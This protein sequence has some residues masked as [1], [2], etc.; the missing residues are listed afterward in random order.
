MEN[1]NLFRYHS[2]QGSGDYILCMRLNISKYYYQ[3]MI[4]TCCPSTAGSGLGGMRELKLEEAPVFQSSHEPTIAS[5]R[6]C[7]SHLPLRTVCL[8]HVD[9]QQKAVTTTT[10]DNAKSSDEPPLLCWDPGSKA[11]WK[12]QVTKSKNHTKIRSTRNYESFL[13]DQKEHK[14]EE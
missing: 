14:R 1:I 13:Q 4:K 5:A 12:K 7:T 8:E 11:A 9:N 10:T 6:Q 3:S 2:W